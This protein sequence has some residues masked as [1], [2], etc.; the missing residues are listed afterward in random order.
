[1]TSTC[2]GRPRST[3][4]L[5]RC[6]RT[7]HT[8][9]T[10][11]C[12]VTNVQ[13]EVTTAGKLYLCVRFRP[14]SIHRT[15]SATQPDSHHHF[16]PEHMSPTSS[17]FASPQPNHRSPA[18]QRLSENE[19]LPP[20][21]SP[22]SFR[23]GEPYPVRLKLSSSSLSSGSVLL[24][25]Y[26]SQSLSRLSNRGGTTDRRDDFLSL[27]SRTSTSAASVTLTSASSR[28][29]ESEDES[30]RKVGDKS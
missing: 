14:N 11:E 6:T 21:P 7:R 20:P 28:T 16:R 12:D 8:R 30:R 1:M 19:P 17:H 24:C 27:T 5:S 18:M 29:E 4:F 2:R 15:Q 9:A 26:F 22:P 10:R 13:Q 23:N 3:T 25:R